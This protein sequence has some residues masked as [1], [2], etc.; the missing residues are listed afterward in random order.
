MHAEPQAQYTTFSLPFMSWCT[1]YLR[2]FYTLFLYLC[3]K[4]PGPPGPCT[5]MIIH[6][7][8]DTAC[9]ENRNWITCDVQ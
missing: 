5:I 2:T 7:I 1:Y 8:L 3:H 6:I 4:N 9:G